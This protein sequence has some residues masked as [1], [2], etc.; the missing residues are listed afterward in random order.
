MP[1]IIIGIYTIYL[2]RINTLI[3]LHPT[4]I[5]NKNIKD[6]IAPV[7]IIIAVSAILFNFVIFFI[8]YI[9]VYNISWGK[10][11]KINPKIDNCSIS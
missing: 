1:L 10:I 3:D 4:G 8:K 2:S 11:E 9:T 6:V 7:V 5:T